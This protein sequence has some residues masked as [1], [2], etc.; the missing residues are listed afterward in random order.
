MRID[1]NDRDRRAHHSVERTLRNFV[2][3]ERRTRGNV[4]R[5]G[6][7]SFGTVGVTALTATAS[8]IG[9][10]RRTRPRRGVR[11]M[12]ASSSDACC[13][14]SSWSA[15]P[16]AA[17][18]SPTCSAV[19][20]C[21]SIAPRS[22]VGERD[23]RAGEL[24]A[25]PREVGRAD[26]DGLLR[27]ARDELVDAR[28]GDE[29]AAPDHD[30]VVGRQRHLAHEMGRDEDG[31]AFR[32]EAFEKVADPVDAFGVE[33][34]DRLVEEHGLRVAEKRGGDAEPLSHAEREL[35]GA[36]ARDVVEADEVDHLEHALLRIAVRL[37]EREKVVVRRAAGVDGARL[38]QRSDLVERR[39][40]VAVVAAVDGDVTLASAR[41]GRG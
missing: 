2:H 29:L 38:E 25:Q 26:E 31:L 28:V 11:S 9:A 17:A 36:L 35:A 3:S 37:R 34:V 18:A 24:L 32:S 13:G 23:A 10:W 12:N 33:A 40:M 7:S 30:Q 6:V 8:S 1:R 14:V 15:M 19:R 27:G 20:P 39:R 16:A 4:T 5:P 22:R 41:R 21:T